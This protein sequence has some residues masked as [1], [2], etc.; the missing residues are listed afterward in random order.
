MNIPVQMPIDPGRSIGAILV[1]AGRLRLEDA[2]IIFRVQQ[3][4]GVR[5]GEA[6]REL[7]LL[8]EEDIQ[9]ALSRQFEY[10]YLLAGESEVS[11]SVM[12][13]YTPAGASIEE[14][15]MLRSQLKLRWFDSEA[16]RKA[17]AV[18]SPERGE[19]R[20]WLAAN[21]AVVFS[22]LGERTLLIDADLRAPSQHKLF[23][24]E[25]RLGLSS[26]LVGRA[27]METIQ[28]VPA[29]LDLSVLPAGAIP[30]N[31]HEL[32]SRLSFSQLLSEVSSTFD[33]IIIDTPPA[34]QCADAQTVSVRASG[35]LMVVR[36]NTSR[37]SRVKAVADSLMQGGVML[38]GSVVNEH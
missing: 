6:A 16:E 8:R 25:G 12:A 33:V 4:R 15:R 38:V 10:P 37:A 34:A 31:P 1:D 35:A 20:S 9:F 3:E 17:L 26:V 14:L 32:L 29:L 30:P 36:R 21:L 5:F 13:A 23:G 11:P 24:L 19:G 7:K 27:G 2:E 28:R 22:Q 18:V